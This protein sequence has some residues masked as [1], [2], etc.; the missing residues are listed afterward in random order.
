M[1]PIVSEQYQFVIGVDTHAATHTLAVLVAATC[2]VLDTDTFPT[3]NRV[4][5]G[6]WPGSLDAV[7][8]ARSPQVD[9]LLEWCRDLC[10]GHRSRSSWLVSAGR[11]GGLRVGLGGAGKN[12]QQ[13][14]ESIQVAV[15]LVCY[16]GHGP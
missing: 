10:G 5:T 7:P 2:S 3:T 1:S 13:I 15:A 12:E 11:P 16:L 9:P 14:G 8:R 4:S 6:P